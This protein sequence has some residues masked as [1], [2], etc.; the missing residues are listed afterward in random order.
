MDYWGAL[1]E[2]REELQ[3]IDRVIVNLEL[4]AV[5]TAAPMFTRRGRKDMSLA[6]RKQVSERMRNYWAS[7]RSRKDTEASTS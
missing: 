1:H 7:R 6:E 4:L 2:L 5:G 3:R